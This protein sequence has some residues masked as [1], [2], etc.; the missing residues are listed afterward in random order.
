MSAPFKLSGALRTKTVP[1][2][3]S[4][5]SKPACSKTLKFCK[6]AV[7]SFL[8]IVTV[9]G[10]SSVCAIAASSRRLSFSYS[11]LSCAA[12]LS[13]NI[14]VCASYSR[15]IYVSN[16]SPITL[17]AVRDK[18]RSVSGTMRVSGCA[19]LSGFSCTASVCTGVSSHAGG[20]GSVS[21]GC[22]K[23]GSSVI[24]SGFVTGC[25]S[26]SKTRSIDVRILSS[27]GF[28]SR[29]AL[30]ENVCGIGGISTGG[31]YGASASFLLVLITGADFTTGA[32]I[33]FTV[34]VFGG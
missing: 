17:C 20:T 14:S 22:G 34:S 30:S 7:Y 9:T 11:S 6:T 4:S 19:L 5:T 27:C 31:S 1:L 33:G 29:S 16:T 28:S 2:P 26:A 24:T 15:M 21:G 8:S 18:S 32:G 10:T 12:C 3:K 13:I 23:G 25:G